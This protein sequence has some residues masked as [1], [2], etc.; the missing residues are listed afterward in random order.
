MTNRHQP[1]HLTKHHGLGNDFLVALAAG[2]PSL[3]PSADRARELCDRHRGLG[4]DGFLWGLTPDGPEND[5]RLVLHNADGSEAEIS[6]N[7]IRCLGQAFLR[8][9]GER[10][11]VVLIETSV[12][13]RRLSCTAT[14][15]DDTDVLEVSMGGVGTGPEVSPV[16]GARRQLSLSVGNPHLVLEVDD[17]AAIDPADRGPAIEEGVPGGIN[18]HFLVP[19]GSDAVRLLHWER[20]AGVTQACGSGAVAAAVAA[21]RWGLATNP[22][23]VRMP[24]GEAVIST[25]DDGASTLL[26]GPATYVAEVWA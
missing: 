17:L 9:R 8:D 16:S 11:G 26:S 19:D 13:L 2:N 14:D 1:L 18:V 21:I 22:V 12:G 15:D 20:G 6:G 25:V 10:T 23:T 3:D 4:A 24:G 7:G 5:L